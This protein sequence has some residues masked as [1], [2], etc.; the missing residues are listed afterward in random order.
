MLK[1]KRDV[2]LWQAQC[3]L[4]NLFAKNSPTVVREPLDTVTDRSTQTAGYARLPPPPTVTS[5]YDYL[6]HYKR[7]SSLA[8]TVVPSVAGSAS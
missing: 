2:P 4:Q 1:I 5:L 7:Y 6:I 3:F 8:A